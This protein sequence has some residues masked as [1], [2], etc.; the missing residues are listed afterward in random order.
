LLV[1]ALAFDTSTPMVSVAVVTKDVPTGEG[2]FVT[3][4]PQIVAAVEEHAPN[5]QGE[6]LAPLMRQ[7]LTDAAVAVNDVDVIGVGLGP[8]PFT[9]LRVG[10]VTALGLADALGVPAHGYCSLDAIAW[11]HSP[12]EDF[13]VVTDARR[14]Q[15][16]WA[17]YGE[18]GDRT[19]GPELAR[20][21]ELAEQL[22]GRVRVVAGAGALLYPEAF[23]GFRVVEERLWPSAAQIACHAVMDH[24]VGKVPGPLAPMYL[25][26]PDARPPA[27]LKKVTPA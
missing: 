26:R 10:V 14:K 13:A 27:A 15:V 24:A 19:A 20:P 4:P 17:T 22:S 1:L 21:E 2:A 6:T 9:G 12:L 8:G 11:L 5:A 7:A 23:A 25:R 18:A 3:A 16:Y